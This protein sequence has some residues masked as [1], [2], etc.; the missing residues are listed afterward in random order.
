MLM[1]LLT[2]TPNADLLQAVF[3]IPTDPD[4]EDGY[5]K[6]SVY[7][8][9]KLF[10][11]LQ[12]SLDSVPTHE[13][14]SAF[15]WDQK[16][17]FEQQDIQELSRVLMERLEEKMKGTD[18]ENALT[19]MFSG[20]MKTF[21]SCINV[22]YESSKVEDFWDIQLNVSG[23]ATLDDSFRDYIQ[24]ETL[25]GDNKYSADNY[26]LQD[27]KKGVIFNSFPQILHLHLKRFEYDYNT[28]MM[29]KI[30]DRYEFPEVWDASPYLSAEADRSRSWNYRLYGVLVHSGDVHAGHYYAFIRPEKN[31]SFYRFDDERVIK[32]TL[33]EATEENFGG[34]YSTGL[35]GSGA[36]RNPYTRAWSTKRS[37]NAYML[38]Y[39]READIDKIL[40]PREEVPA[41]LHLG[42]LCF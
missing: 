7:A 11:R 28:D 25:E 12:T 17:I 31:G 21:I 9:Q 13:L 10:Y 14:T 29:M 33:R 38:V 30:N 19:D 6:D 35:N 3:Q 36:Q 39:F 15:G 22:N 5:R 40:L 42:M 26:G 1:S 27:A 20:K 4:P 32:S 41:P 24:E 37:M 16:Q 8:L 23:N 34:E 2:A 18:A